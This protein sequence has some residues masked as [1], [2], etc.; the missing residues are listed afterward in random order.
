M[1]IQKINVP[2]IGDFS[3]VEVIEVFVEVGDSVELETPLISIETDKAVM[4]VP[5]TH[6][7]V[8]TAI[9]ANLGDKVSEGSA[10]IDVEVAEAAASTETAVEVETASEVAT[11]AAPVA[12]KAEPKLIQVKVPD[13][14]DFT[15]V[16]IIESFVSVGDELE[17]EAPLISLETDK[18][19]MDVP[20]PEAGTVKAVHI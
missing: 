19:V 7:G 17:A 3:D 8:V 5:S 16:E 13:I 6:V 14:G 2:D 11:V 20:A 9:H 15:D 10:V 1:T 4:D 18:A 12:A